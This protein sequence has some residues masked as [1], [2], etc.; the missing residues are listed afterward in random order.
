MR[1][2]AEM[3]RRSREL[4]TDMTPSERK[5]WRH[6]RSREAGGYKFRRQHVVGHFI[7]DFCCPAAR[8]VVEL[9][10]ESHLGREKHDV[11]RQGLLEAEGLKVLRFWD[12][13]VHEQ[14][15]AVVEAIYRE[16][17]ARADKAPSP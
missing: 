16:C 5:L 11:R 10:G 6:L 17:E 14:L 12:T 3:K 1:R 2:N 15:D 9:D 7:V 13:E 4:R 8:L